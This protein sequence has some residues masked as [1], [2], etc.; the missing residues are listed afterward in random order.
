MSVIRLVPRAI[1]IA[2]QGVEVQDRGRGGGPQP[3][4]APTRE[5]GRNRNQEVAPTGNGESILC[6]STGTNPRC[7]LPAGTK[8]RGGEIFGTDYTD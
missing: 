8:A 2:T 7:D 4:V 5:E 1:S 6:R 3:K